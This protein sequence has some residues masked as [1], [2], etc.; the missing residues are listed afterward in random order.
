M[1]V[2][3]E[4]VAENTNVHLPFF[5]SELTPHEASLLPPDC[6]PLFVP[7]VFSLFRWAGG[8][9]W[10]LLAPCWMLVEWQLPPCM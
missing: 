5:H 9:Y 2:G 3:H 7:D 1:P 4:A 10:P 8:M 6:P